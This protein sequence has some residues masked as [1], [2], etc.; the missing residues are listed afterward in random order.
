MS[1]YIPRSKAEKEELKSL[2]ENIRRQIEA[3]NYTPADV[4][5][6]RAESVQLGL[7]EKLSALLDQAEQK[8]DAGLDFDLAD[9]QEE[10][11]PE[12]RR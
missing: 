12:D 8:L 4:I 9:Y 6:W 1:E 11:R 10:D 7:G 5:G 3:G 2:L